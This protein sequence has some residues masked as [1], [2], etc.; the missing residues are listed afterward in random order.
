MRPNSH[1]ALQGAHCL[2]AD[3][4]KRFGL[5]GQSRAHLE[6]LDKI[7]RVAGINVEILITGPTG[8][9]KELYARYLHERSARSAKPFVPVNCAN[10]QDHLFENELFGHQAG[11]FTGAQQASEGLVA[12]AEGGTLLLDEVQNL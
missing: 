3:E 11:A 9:G 4:A 2:V 1:G 6:L 10:V 12:A 5:V 7:V 8:V